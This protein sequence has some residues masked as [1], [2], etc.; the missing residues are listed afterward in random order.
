MDEG[1]RVRHIELMDD[2]VVGLAPPAVAPVASTPDPAAS[3]PDPAPTDPA[4]TDPAPTDP[5]GDTADTSAWEAARTRLRVVIGR[6]GEHPDAISWPVG[7]VLEARAVLGGPG[8]LP[9]DQQDC[10]QWGVDA[11]A[12]QA[13]SLAN[14]AATDPG[15]DPVG[16]GQ[17]A[18]VPT[19]PADHPPAWLAAPDRLLAACGLSA[20]V[21]LAPLPT[22]LVVVDPDAHELL[23]SILT[24][25]QTIVTGGSQLL[26]PAPFLVTPAGVAPW[27]PEPDHPCAPAVVAL[28]RQA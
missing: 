6:P 9:V 22:E 24:S 10:A 25:T 18:W 21:V 12:V 7:A 4:P 3:S 13:A 17:P 11:A 5:A 26:W 27:E 14:L 2:L 15:L 20:A 23:G 1:E 8:A 16:P 28:G 19:Q